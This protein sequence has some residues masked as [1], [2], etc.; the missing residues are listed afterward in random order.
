MIILIQLL[1][2]TNSSTNSWTGLDWPSDPTSNHRHRPDKEED[3]DAGPVQ[4]YSSMSCLPT[5]LERPRRSPEIASDLSEVSNELALVTRSNR[6]RTIRSAPQRKAEF[7]HRRYWL[8]AIHARQY[9]NHHFG[10]KHSG[11]RGGGCFL[12]IDW[13]LGSSED[14]A[15]RRVHG[16]NP[17][18]DRA[19][20]RAGQDFDSLGGCGEKQ[21]LS[22]LP[23]QGGGEA[24]SEL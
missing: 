22:F 20:V 19:K 24:A 18:G 21:D 3:S 13:I 23:G 9:R 10:R 4:G 5:T 15:A 17:A 12:R 14:V 8:R 1:S 7:H 6:L 11:G 16:V 2:V